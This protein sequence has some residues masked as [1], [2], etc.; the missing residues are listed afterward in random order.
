MI[1]WIYFQ[2]KCKFIVGL[3]YPIYN[4]THSII[5]I[6]NS[7]HQL[8]QGNIFTDFIKNVKAALFYP[9]LNVITETLLADWQCNYFSIRIAIALAAFFFTDTMNTY[10]KIMKQQL[11][12]AFRWYFNCEALGLYSS[13]PVYFAFE[14]WTGNVGYFPPSLTFDIVLKQP[15]VKLRLSFN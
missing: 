15:L 3:R 1:Q 6:S 14:I 10:P 13:S 4:Y 11:F 8:Y 9:Y 2:F 7:I 5:E 12:E